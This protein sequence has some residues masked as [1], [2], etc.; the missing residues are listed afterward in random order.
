MSS[1]YPSWLTPDG[2]IDTTRVPFDAFISQAV[3]SEVKEFASACHL[4]ESLASQGRAEAGV[5]LLDLLSFYCDD[6]CR[7][8]QVVEA[9]HFFRCPASAQALLAELHRLKWSN[10]TRRSLNAVV[11]ALIRSPHRWFL[12]A[13]ARS[14]RT[15]ANRLRLGAGTAP[16][17][18][19][20]HLA[21][22]TM[23]S[24]SKA[25]P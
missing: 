18:M 25:W 2:R 9:L 11:A 19:A 21:R 20:S 7:L 12:Q 13:S 16:S 17:W 4:L 15:Q 14:R 24:R 6:L 10:T 3:S 23:A 1:H 8:E 5:F 22:S